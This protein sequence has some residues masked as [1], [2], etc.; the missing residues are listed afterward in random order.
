[1]KSSPIFVIVASSPKVVSAPKVAANAQ[2][3][4][5]R[6]STLGIILQQTVIHKHGKYLTLHLKAIKSLGLQKI[7]LHRR[8]TY[9]FL[10]DCSNLST[11][12]T[13]RRYRTIR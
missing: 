8:E 3:I 5:L 12:S 4:T 2:K 10:S 7:T 9:R 11:V 1:M 6:Y 13:I